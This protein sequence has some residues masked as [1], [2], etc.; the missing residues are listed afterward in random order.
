MCVCVGCDIVCLSVSLLVIWF[1]QLASKSNLC[2]T[3][4]RNN[5][6]TVIKCCDAVA[7]AAARWWSFVRLVGLAGRPNAKIYWHCRFE[8]EMMIQ[9]RVACW[10]W[11]GV[12]VF[13]FA[14]ILNLSFHEIS[15]SKETNENWRDS[16]CRHSAPHTPIG[17]FLWGDTHWT[18]WNEHI[19]KRLNHH[20]LNP[21]L[22]PLPLFPS[23][24]ICDFVI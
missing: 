24:F 15:Q 3:K 21:Q 10:R 5:K 23:T 7:I 11:C 22:L 4:R 16:I 14:C 6:N 19:A 20:T 18:I 12:R 9:R 17:W 8:I 13:S 2:K 1:C